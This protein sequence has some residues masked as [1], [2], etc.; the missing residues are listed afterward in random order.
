MT[1]FAFAL[2]LVWTLLAL[3]VI[4]NLLVFPELDPTDPSGPPETWPMVSIVIPARNE[5]RDVGATLDAALA[6]DY[7]RLEVIVVD[8]GSTDGT[9]AEIAARAADP[10]LV[11]VSCPPLP[12]GWLGKPHALSNGTAVARGDWLLLMDADVRLE[13]G[14][15]RGA[16]G[17]S[18]TKGWDHLA[19]LPHF[20]RVGFWEEIAMPSLFVFFFIFAPSFLALSRRHKLAFG[21]GAFN[22][23]R[24]EAYDAIGGHRRLARSVV[25][26]VRLAMELKA[27]GFTTR[28]RLG[29]RLLRL[30]M[31]H[32]LGE[33]IEGFTKNAHAIWA[34]RE[35][36]L[37]FV[38]S[39]LLAINMLPFF[40]IPWAVSSPQQ[41]L[42]PPLLWLGVS[43]ALLMICRALIQW[44]L[45]LPFWPAI[46]HPLSV[47]VSYVI[48]ARSLRMVYGEGIVRWRGREYRRETTS[49]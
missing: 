28:I 38:S 11:A 25:D 1:Y 15:L 18:E 6:Q 3:Q 4:I 36:L 8:D 26:D 24:R 30:R 29:S 9:A 14:T 27:A 31:Y 16:V 2:F 35:A 49:F 33:I 34:G 22:L 17:R 5:E 12:E 45:G 23:V 19:L 46:F 40:W 32:G 10:R 44:R 21:G 43:L 47:L 48:V 13:P 7:P 37:V 42:L 20:E 39:V 41:A